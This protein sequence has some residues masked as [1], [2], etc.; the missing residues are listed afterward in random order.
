MKK[1]LKIWSIL[2]EHVV[3]VCNNVFMSVHRDYQR[4][5]IGRQMAEVIDRKLRLLGGTQAAVAELSAVGTQKV[6]LNV[7]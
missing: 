7:K 1:N 6:R 4:F 2:P 3:Q 5:G